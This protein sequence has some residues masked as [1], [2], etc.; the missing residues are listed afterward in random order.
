MKRRGHHVHMLDHGAFAARAQGAIM[1]RNRDLALNQQ[2]AEREQNH[3]QMF[4]QKAQAVTP[5]GM[6]I[7]VV[8][9]QK[10]AEYKNSAC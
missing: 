2:P 5:A 9:W 3:Q 8:G 1:G 7:R 10:E 6:H 4:F